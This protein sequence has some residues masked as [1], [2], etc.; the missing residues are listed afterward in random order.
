MKLFGQSTFGTRTG[1]KDLWAL[2]NQEL[3]CFLTKICML[4]TFTQ[5]K[6]CKGFLRVCYACVACCQK[7]TKNDRVEPIDK[8]KVKSKNPTSK[9]IFHINQSY[10]CR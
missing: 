8:E 9:I 2:Y 7:V 1:F 3:M 10:L 4:A 6:K 5:K